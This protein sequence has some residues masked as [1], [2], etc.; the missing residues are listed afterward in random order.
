M[1]CRR[2]EGHCGKT[3]CRR[4]NPFVSAYGGATSPYT[5]EA[6]V[7]GCCLLHSGRNE[8]P[9]RQPFRLRLRRSHLPLHRGGWVRG[10]VEACAQTL[11]SARLPC[12]KGAGCPKGRL[13]DC[14]P[15][16]AVQGKRGTQREK[17]GSDS[18]T[19][20]SPPMAEPP[21]LT[22]GRLGCGDVVSCTAG[23]TGCRRVNPFVSAYGGATS[24]Y[25]G[26]A[27]CAGKLKPVRRLWEARGSLE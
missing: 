12:V 16:N 4:G 21:P 27:G 14:G 7:R 10:K 26:E 2:R 5:G 1:H 22:Q 24:P 8:V 17:R 19:L 13:R 3:G 23:K 11:G 25:T 9:A 15:G 6:W 20:S 18:A